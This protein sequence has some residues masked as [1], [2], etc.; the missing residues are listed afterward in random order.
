MPRAQRL[1]PDKLRLVRCYSA[2]L[3]RRRINIT[4]PNSTAITPQ[5]T[6]KVVE[7]ITKSPSPFLSA[8]YM[9]SIIGKRSRT[10]RVITGPTVTTNRDGSTQK[11]IGKT[12]LTASLEAR[13]SALCRAMVRR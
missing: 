5:I 9:F 3:L 2:L 7:S 12:S 4:T 10:R 8:N 1:P 11:K 13:S 6:R